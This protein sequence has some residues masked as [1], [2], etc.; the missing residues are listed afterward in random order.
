[1]KKV[2][3]VVRFTKKD[4]KGIF[5]LEDF[6]KKFVPEIYEE[7][8]KIKDLRQIKA[9]QKTLDELYDIM[10]DNI[11]K[12]KDKR[13]N[14]Y[15]VRCRKSIIAMDWLCYSPYTSEKVEDFALEVVW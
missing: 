13:V 1:M 11:L 14:G 15:S 5:C 12:S 6:Y 2:R 8:N 7:E 9:N 4:L 10:T 3:K